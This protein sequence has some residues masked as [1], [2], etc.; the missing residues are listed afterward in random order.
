MSMRTKR[1]LVYRLRNPFQ[2]V[3]LKGRGTEHQPINV[4]DFVEEVESVVCASDEDE[5]ED[6]HEDDEVDEVDE[7]E[8]EEMVG[9]NL[10]AGDVAENA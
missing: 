9:E 3:S 7:V 1:T 8:K 4:D 6:G 5:V 10:E 2:A